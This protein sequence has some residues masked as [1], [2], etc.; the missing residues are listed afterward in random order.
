[1]YL[2]SLALSG[3][4]TFADDTALQFGKGITAI[5]GPN[6]SGKSNV[7]DG[8][9]W[10]LGERSHKALRGHAPTDVIF[11][12]SGA[13]KLMG[14]AEV[15]LFFDNSDKSLPLDFNEVQVT[16]RIF[17]DGESEYAINKAKSRLRD[18]T[19]LFL[20]TGVGPD[21]YTIISQSEID[22]ILSAKAEDRRGLIEGAAGVQKYRARRTET[23]RKLDRVEADLLRVLDIT[24]E[25]E[26]Q[27]AP[28]AEQAELAREHDNYVRRLRELQL[29]ILAREYD[30][31][32]K[33]K[34]ALDE[35]KNAAQKT[36]HFE[37]ALIEKL[38][39]D[40]R[41]LETQMRELEAQMDSLQSETTD[42]V[43]RLKATEGTIAVARER[44]R[45]LTEQQEFQSQEIGLLRGRINIAQE[46]IAAQ[47]RELDEAVRD[48]SLLSSGAADAEAK[49][50]AAVAALSEATRELQQRQSRVIETMRLGQTKREAAAGG[51]AEA[52]GLQNRLQ[53]LEKL[54]RFAGRRTAK[55]Q[56]CAS[57]N[58]RRT[59][60]NAREIETRGNRSSKRARHDC[61]C[62]DRVLEVE[63]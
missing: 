57:Q 50:G 18:V 43:S 41:T 9:L 47:K 8:I 34:A 46:T 58:P 11:N 1:M 21:A 42:V 60:S 25:L 7:V 22:S 36:T 48:S 55:R 37:T 31:R 10:A 24:V 30:V 44:R 20:D 54:L 3:F 63:R 62:A 35:A 28:L 14:M 61:K 32:Q 4:K 23:R 17:R 49:L 19:D 40:E 53:D 5:V 33:R 45:A 56:R 38:E 27:L 52:Q 39:N 59:P 29:A 13:R 12:G 16:R 15:S 6:G 2:K 51:R 26:S